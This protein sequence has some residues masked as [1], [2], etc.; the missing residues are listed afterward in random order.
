[1]EKIIVTGGAGFIGSHIVDALIEEGYE[2][3]V[4]DNMSAG[5]KENIN[6]KAVLH[7]VDIREKEKLIPIFTNAKYVFHE[8]AFPQVQYSIENPVE[9][10]AINVEG[11]LNILEV[12]RINKVK[13]VIFASSSAVY[14]DQDIL[15]ITESMEASPLSPYGAQKYIGEVYMKLYAQIYG[16]ETI[17]LRYFNV[18]GPRQSAS[19]A[20]AS[21]IPK[22]IEFRQKN[23]P[24][25][26]TGDGEQTRDF[27]N[28]KDIVSA[29]ILAM[30]G[31]KVG[32]GEVLNIG[33]N[34][35]YSINYIAKLV[36][37]EVSYI[38]PRIEPRNTQAG[39]SKAKEFLNWEPRVVLEEGIEEL[40]KYN[41]I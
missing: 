27:V 24:L 39:I 22:F 12:S 41:N 33:G 23:E 32:K 13:R 14:G 2:V 28:V 37:G 40:K 35:Q 4:V 38:P 9:T 6:P 30:K 11:T 16:V 31:D 18:Y 21:A 5:R 26:I 34:N 10:N 1:M 36:G 15:P 3:H 20:Y 29:N 7:I 8:A 19:G 25:S 17:S